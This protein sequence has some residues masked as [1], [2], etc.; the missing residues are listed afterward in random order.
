MTN[1]RSRPMDLTTAIA[2]PWR[3][4]H[5]SLRWIG[6]VVCLLLCIGAL[7]CALL[8]PGR[9]GWLYAMVAYGFGAAYFWQWVMAA[10]LLVGIDTRRLRIPGIGR[11]MATCLGL[12]AAAM[13]ALPT[14]AL[15]ALGGEGST[16]ALFTA[17]AIATGVASVLLPRRYVMVLAF[18]PALAVALRHVIRLPLPGQT[19]FLAWGTAVLVA[20]LAVDVL[21]WRHL[22]QAEVVCEEDG[23]I[24]R[25]GRRGAVGGMRGASQVGASGRASAAVSQLRLAGVGP[26]T[27]VLALRVAL[28]EGYAPQGLR[29]HAR[30]FMRFGLPL[31]LFIPLMAIMHAGETQGEALRH[32]LFGV[33]IDVI[34]W[35]GIM[36][37]LTLM[38]MGSLL[39]WA[40]WRRRRPELSLLALLPGLGGVVAVRRALLRA[41]L[42]RPLALQTGLLALVLI[43]AL[44]LHANATLLVFVVLSQFGCAATVAA[45]SLGAFGG[46]PLPGWGIALILAG[47]AVLVAAS[48]FV[49]L[50]A[51]LGRHPWHAGHAVF[52]M[53]AVA[54]IFAAFALGWLGRRGWRGMQARPHPFLAD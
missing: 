6:S 33:G 27:P 30:R 28:G 41:T 8:I 18:L 40:S 36:G 26:G 34:G 39:P 42:G 21:R 44:L 5:P 29:G 7:A 4:T 51:T 19:G 1:T 17:L 35:L 9:H 3:T 12:Y 11:V 13:I 2:M 24:I 14:A 16:V 31:L 20:L 52:A 32:V 37:G 38:V 23:Q 48:T 49:P 54:W 22:L 50:L 25:Y 15:A 43:A 53:L 10:L 46:C 45:T 47:M